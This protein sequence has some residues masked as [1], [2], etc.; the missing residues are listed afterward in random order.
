MYPGVPI[1]GIYDVAVAEDNSS[2]GLTVFQS[3]CPKYQAGY[4][5]MKP[6]D[7]YPLER[8]AGRSISWTSF[9]FSNSVTIHVRVLDSGKIPLNAS[10]KIFPSRYGV[11]PV[12]DKDGINFTITQPGQYSVEIGEDGYQNGL[13][14][15]ANPPETDRPDPATGNYYS[16]TDATAEKINAVPASYA[17]IYFKSGVHDIGVYHV[18]GNVK[19]IYFEPGAWV[20]GAIVMEGRSGVKIFG[21]GVLSEAKLDYPEIACGGSAASQRSN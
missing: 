3:S 14:I 12:V 13:L 17:G 21:R 2:R 20:Y 15:F 5:N 19:N 10:V 1:S 8:F 6:V 7:R 16:L 11:T 18:P 9:S 4:Q